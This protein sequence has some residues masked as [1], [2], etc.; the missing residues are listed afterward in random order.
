MAEPVEFASLLRKLGQEARLTQEALA[1]AA[2]VSVRAVSDL[3]RG[4]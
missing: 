1:G 2:G 4:W 3:E